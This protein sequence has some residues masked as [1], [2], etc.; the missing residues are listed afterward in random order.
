MNHIT[1][2]GYT[3]T[4]PRTSKMEVGDKK[5][6]FCDFGIAVKDDYTTEEDSTDFFWLKTYGKQAE[7]C[8]KFLT[9][10]RRIV[11]EGKL[12]NPPIQSK[13]GGIFYRPHI[14]VS[15]VEI[16]DGKYEEGDPDTSS[17]ITSN[18][19]LSGLEGAEFVT[20]SPNA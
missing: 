4:D 2:S 18:V 16:A 7:F 3:S 20:E 15:R 12:K 13:K 9:K 14:D 17:Y 6:I 10:G 8:Q 19:D 11:V 5:Y 1:L